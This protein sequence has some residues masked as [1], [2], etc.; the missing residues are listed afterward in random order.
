[1]LHGEHAAGAGD[2]GLDL[3]DDEQDAVL[4][5]DGAQFAQKVEGR[6]V[7]A[8]LALDRLDDDRRHPL[9]LDVGGEELLEIGH[10]GGRV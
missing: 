7:E 2:A 8:A 10:G 3:V 6:D 1:M 4:V 9:R 5:A